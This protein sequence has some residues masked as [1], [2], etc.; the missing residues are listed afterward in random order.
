M[1]M[2]TQTAVRGISWKRSS[3]VGTSAGFA[4]EGTQS[5]KNHDRIPAS[6]AGFD[7]REQTLLEFRDGHASPLHL[8][9]KKGFP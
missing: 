9:G 2:S 7:V 1:T 6:C 3:R 5:P 4:F 8:G